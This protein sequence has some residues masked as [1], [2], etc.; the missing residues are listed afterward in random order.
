MATRD[1]ATEEVRRYSKRHET[2]DSHRAA[3]EA[4]GAKIAA[5]MAAAKA[6]AYS[7]PLKRTPHQQL[8]IL[9]ARLGKGQGAKKE[10]ARLMAKLGLK[11]VETPKSPKS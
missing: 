9:D 2:F 11:P 3:V 8:A 1:T 6:K 5:E 4:Y 7:L 10:R